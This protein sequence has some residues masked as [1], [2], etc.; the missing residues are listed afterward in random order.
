MRIHPVAAALLLACACAPAAGAQT[1]VLRP[2]S[3]GV[4]A[5]QL[6]GGVQEFDLVEQDGNGEPTDA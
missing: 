5:E 4:F 2:G 6:N 1:I 3:A